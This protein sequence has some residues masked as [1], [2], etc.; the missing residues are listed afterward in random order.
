M[1]DFGC[2]KLEI[3]TY[4]TDKRLFNLLLAETGIIFPVVNWK[5]FC[6]VV[7]CLILL[8]NS[9]LPDKFFQTSQTKK[10]AKLAG[11][12]TVFVLRCPFT[13]TKNCEQIISAGQSNLTESPQFTLSFFYSPIV[14]KPQFVNSAITINNVIT[15]SAIV[16]ILLSLN[17]RLFDPW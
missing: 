15:N 11:K 13:E 2:P 5:K 17:N 6:P 1:S 3:G 8:C 9:T 12:K 16:H 14:R 10:N 7:N 4:F